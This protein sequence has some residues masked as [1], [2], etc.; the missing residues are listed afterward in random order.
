M[1][2]ENFDLSYILAMF[3]F[4]LRIYFDLILFSIDLYICCVCIVNSFLFLTIYKEHITYKKIYYSVT[5]FCETRTQRSVEEFRGR[6]LHTVHH[7]RDIRLRKP[8]PS[9]TMTDI[10]VKSN[11]T[12]GILW[13]T[14]EF[15]ISVCDRFPGLPV[16]CY[17][18]YLSLPMH[19]SSM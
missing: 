16:T 3:F 15:K 10:V 4:F 5:L 11:S 19:M 17:D 8:S 13:N 9:Q 14:I 18:K 1:I 6:N 7:R 2:E 12:V